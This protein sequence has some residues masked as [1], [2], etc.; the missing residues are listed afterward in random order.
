MFDFLRERRD[1]SYCRESE[2]VIQESAG[3]FL[4][5]NAYR[6]EFLGRAGRYRSECLFG[7][8]SGDLPK[9]IFGGEFGPCAWIGPSGSPWSELYDEAAYWFN[10]EPLA[11]FVLQRGQTW[12]DSAD[13]PA[14]HGMDQVARDISLVWPTAVAMFANLPELAEFKRGFERWAEVAVEE[15]QARKDAEYQNLVSSKVASSSGQESPYPSDSARDA[16]YSRFK[17]TFGSRNEA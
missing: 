7:A 2:Q 16:I 9:I 3:A 15:W 11:D 4:A 14:G 8:E 6:L 1:R 10:V 12:L 13:Q 5:A 17:R